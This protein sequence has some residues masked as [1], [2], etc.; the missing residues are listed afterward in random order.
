[1]GST[2][3]TSSL[4]RANTLKPGWKGPCHHPPADLTA[5]SHARS[6]Q[7]RD[8][9]P[10][11]Q[12]LC[13]STTSISTFLCWLHKPSRSHRE[14]IVVLQPVRSRASAISPFPPDPSLASPG[15]DKDQVST[16]IR[17]SS[18]HQ[19]PA[20]RNKLKTLHLLSQTT[21]GIRQLHQDLIAA[22]H[23]PARLDL[24]F[25]FTIPSF[26]PAT[27]PATTH[28][29]SQPHPATMAKKPEI[30][31]AETKLSC[32]LYACSFDHADPTCLVVGGGGGSDPNGVPNEVVCHASS[33][34]SVYP[35]PSP[36]SDFTRLLS[37]LHRRRP[38]YAWACRGGHRAQG[39]QRA[40]A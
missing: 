10:T 2:G 38:S 23:T 20:R 17:P 18:A 6:W 13:A 40:G 8:K 4:D 11:A 39:R 36:R 5:P 12:P 27:A 32:P 34:S 25:S 28:H 31:Q 1:M 9:Q 30:L 3:G 14:A 35:S 33:V 16:C 37:R 29:S 19:Q 7:Q 24:F 15:H 26:L 21:A 22:S